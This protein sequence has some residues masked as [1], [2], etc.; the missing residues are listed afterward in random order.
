MEVVNLVFVD[1]W[2]IYFESRELIEKLLEI[3]KEVSK[4]CS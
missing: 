1:I 4:I 2:S 3:I